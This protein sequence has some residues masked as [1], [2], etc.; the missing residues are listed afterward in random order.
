MCAGGPC[1]AL[2][3]SLWPPKSLPRAEQV[4]D[5]EKVKFCVCVEGKGLGISIHPS[6]EGS[7]LPPP[8]SLSFRPGM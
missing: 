5:T 1:P 6:S 8:C 7:S 3:V 4:K 2:S